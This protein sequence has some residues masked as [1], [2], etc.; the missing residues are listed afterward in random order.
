[1]MWYFPNFKI[2]TK[3]FQESINSSIEL[4][5]F[6]ILEFWDQYERM[7]DQYDRMVLRAILSY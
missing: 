1:M 6:G 4:I 5:L 7:Q 3:L 2:R